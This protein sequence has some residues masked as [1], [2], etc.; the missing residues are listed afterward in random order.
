MGQTPPAAPPHPAPPHPTESHTGCSRGESLLTALLQEQDQSSGPEARIILVIF[1]D[2][3]SA[4]NKKKSSH[5]FI[6]CFAMK[7]S[8]TLGL[9]NDQSMNT[10]CAR[11]GGQVSAPPAHILNLNFQIFWRGGA[12]HRKEEGTWLRPHS[13]SL[14]G[15]VQT[16]DI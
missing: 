16:Q 14:R 7:S 9:P 13:R 5:C 6:G 4:S 3:Q 2:V 1:L 8:F 11:P 10:G 12:R 15:K